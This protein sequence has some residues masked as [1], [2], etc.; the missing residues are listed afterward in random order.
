MCQFYFQPFII[1]EQP[2]ILLTVLFIMILCIPANL[3]SDLKDQ[4]KET[5]YIKDED[6]VHWVVP[7]LFL[8]KMMMKVYYLLS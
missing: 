8:F 5:S 2:S 4:D 7:C 1:N 6:I 3:G